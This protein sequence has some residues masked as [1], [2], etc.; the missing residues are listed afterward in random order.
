MNFHVTYLLLLLVIP[1]SLLSQFKASEDVYNNLQK[2]YEQHNGKEVPNCQF[3]LPDG[4]HLNLHD[5]DGKLIVLEFWATWCSPCVGSI[6]IMNTIHQQ[7]ESNG[8]SDIEWIWVSVDSDTARWREFVHRYEMCGTTVLTS[9]EQA[10]KNFEI[11]GYPFYILIDE[12]KRVIGYDIHKPH[13]YGGLM[14]YILCSAYKG[15]S[16]GAAFRSAFKQGED[17]YF[18]PSQEFKDWEKEYNII[19]EESIWRTTNR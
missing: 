17:G 11:V 14:E 1:S 18:Y 6:P 10:R 7:L 12:R 4:N 19:Q 15:I 16:S 9:I 3:L 2:V 13:K 5:I 8:Y